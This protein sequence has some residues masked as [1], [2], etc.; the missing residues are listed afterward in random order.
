MTKISALDTAEITIRRAR[1]ARYVK[2]VMVACGVICVAAGARAAVS[3]SRGD[4]APK[5]APAAAVAVANDTTTSGSDLGT[6]APHRRAL[7]GADAPSAHQ[8]ESEALRDTARTRTPAR[9]TIAAKRPG[10]H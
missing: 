1:L 7:A 4:P 8:L 5:A 3:S 10:R 6:P 2:S 9:S